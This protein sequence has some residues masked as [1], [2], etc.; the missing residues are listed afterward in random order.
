[1]PQT[2]LL[3]SCI[4]DY[5][6]NYWKGT[7]GKFPVKCDS[8]QIESVWLEIHYLLSQRQTDKYNLLI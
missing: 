3:I 1:M 7:L 5:G 2:L 8:L 4:R 6:V